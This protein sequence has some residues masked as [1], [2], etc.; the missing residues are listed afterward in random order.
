[1]LGTAA[2]ASEERALSI[3]AGNRRD[4]V[5][6][7]RTVDGREVVIDRIR[8]R[9]GKRNPRSQQRFRAADAADGTRC[10]R[11]RRKPRSRRAQ[12]RC[13]RSARRVPSGS[14]LHRPAPS[15]R[16]PALRLPAV[17]NTPG[18]R[19]RRSRAHRLANR[20]WGEREIHA[21]HSTWFTARPSISP[22]R[23]S[24]GALVYKAFC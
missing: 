11:R 23:A 17:S 3:P 7:G 16:R 13:S 2:A 22:N 20:G 6:V 24:R 12:R 18:A 9:R 14:K 1:M 21:N 10:T 19:A 8:Q 5:V 15:S 4:L